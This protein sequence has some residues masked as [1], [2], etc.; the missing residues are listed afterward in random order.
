MDG[1]GVLA[2]EGSKGTLYDSS[3]GNKIGSGQLTLP[4]RTDIEYKFGGKE[5]QIDRSMSKAEFTSGACFGGQVML[6]GGAAAAPPAPSTPLST[7]KSTRQYIPPS[8]SRNT[9][10]IPKPALFS[11]QPP[12]SASDDQ[13]KATTE[14]AES[15]WTVNWRKPQNKKQVFWEGDGLIHQVGTKLTFYSEEGKVMGTTNSA[16]EVIA[17]GFSTTIGGKIVELDGEIT[18]EDFPWLQDSSAQ[19]VAA[20][21][22]ATPL[23]STFVAPSSFY[24]R[25]TEPQKP[26]ADPMHDPNAEGAV[27]MKSPTK[28][29]MKRYNKD[30]FPVV[31]VVLDPILARHLR[32]H[33]KEGVKFMYECVMGLRKHEGQGCILADEMGLGK[34]L[35]TVALVWTLLKQSPYADIR[36]PLSKAL[37]VCP[38]SLVKNWKMEFHKWLGKDR[39]QVVIWGD[40]NAISNFQNNK[41]AHVLVLGYERLK[42]VVEQLKLCVPPIGLIICDEGHRLKSTNNKT[43]AM[44]QHLKTPRRILLSGTPIQNDLSEFHAMASF[45]N[46]GLLDEYTTFRQVYENPILRS[47]APDSTPKETELG[48][49]RLAQLLTISRSFVLRRDATILDNYLPPKTEYVVFVKPTQLQ[50]SMFQKILTK[51]IDDWVGSSTSESLA[52]INVLTKISN[53][54]ILLKATA[55]KSKENSNSIMRPGVEEAVKLLPHSRVEDLGLSGKLTALAQLLAALHKNTEEKVVLVSHYVSTLNIM[56]AFCQK[57]KYPFFRLDGQTPPQK[58]QEYVNQFNKSSHRNSFVF[59]LSSKAGGVGINLIGASRLCLI[60]QD[61]NPS[62]DLQSMARIHRDGQ[63][64]PV[65]IYRFLTTGAIDEKIFQ[66]QVTKLGLSSSLIDSSKSGSKSDSFSRKELRDIFRI[67]LDT[68]CHTHDLLECPCQTEEYIENALTPAVDLDTAGQSDSADEDL[69]RGFVNA[70]QLKPPKASTRKE[71]QTTK[72]ALASLGEWKHI[73]CVSRTAPQDIEDDLL[74]HLVSEGLENLP[75]P[76][77]SDEEGDE[78]PV[79]LEDLKAGSVSF[80]F[81]KIS[82]VKASA[83]P[84]GE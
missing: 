27:V 16:P 74:R 81:E 50:V 12:A 59:L 39:V 22:I 47:R 29:H 2:L 33:Q 4:L 17:S 21:V 64:R 7:H 44:F 3:D 49:A 8:M 28:E 37:I 51:N 75:E 57:M 32:P 18:R 23:K 71:R 62:H 52:M 58:R 25:S 70:S 24:N 79:M 26:K 82:R 56:E 60:D 78:A 65:F 43:S 30:N 38:V 36:P 40:S 42:T 77:P 45:C 35:Q 6:L 67:H 63:K 31:P 53:S 54:P 20:S 48:K 55:D 19:P 5:I 84:E 72:A 13:S 10:S 14:L 83:A 11:K 34:T 69:E 80:L 9:A 73:N 46:P 15:Y 68:A 1:D 76:P 66:R 41:R 61:W